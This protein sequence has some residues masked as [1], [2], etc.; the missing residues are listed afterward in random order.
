[1]TDYWDEPVRGK[2]Y[3][4]VTKRRLLRR[5]LE[6]PSE[7]RL[8]RFAR[9]LWAYRTW[10]S[11]E[12]PVDER[13]LGQGHTPT[14]FRDFLQAVEAG[15]TSRSA[16]GTPSLGTWVM[17]EILEAMNP[18]KYATLNADARTGM[19]VLGYTT[20]EKP[21][22]NGDEYWAFVENVKESVERFDLQNRV[23]ESNIDEIPKDVPAVDI[24]QLAFLMH[25]ADQ[26]DVDLGT[27][28]EA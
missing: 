14:E 6:E 13:L 24:A 8:K 19:E 28:S 10:A 3:S 12:F 9:S 7:E 2:Q 4:I 18:E 21:L 15:E 5:F 22:Q 16:P 27:V 11:V 1:M 17:S 26:F 20:P 25:S 23:L